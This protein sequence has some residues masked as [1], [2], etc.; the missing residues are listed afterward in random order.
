[1]YFILSLFILNYRNKYER[2][3]WITCINIVTTDVTVGLEPGDTIE[4]GLRRGFCPIG[5][6]IKLFTVYN[7]FQFVY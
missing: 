1:M 5:D 3:S 2:Q 6:G 7:W 4:T